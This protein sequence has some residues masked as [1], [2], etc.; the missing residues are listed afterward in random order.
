MFHKTSMGPKRHALC[1]HEAH[2]G[3]QVIEYLMVGGHGVLW[4]SFHMMEG[5]KEVRQKP[6][7]MSL[8]VKGERVF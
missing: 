3:R 5:I 2:S 8:M 7:V 6:E 1:P 4:E